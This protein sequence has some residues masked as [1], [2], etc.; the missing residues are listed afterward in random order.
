MDAKD[1]HI[2]AAMYGE[3]V[4]DQNPQVVTTTDRKESTAFFFVIFVNG[5]VYAIATASADAFS[6]SSSPWIFWSSDHGT[7]GFWGI[8]QS[9]YR[10]GMTEADGIPMHLIE[11]L[12]IF[13]AT[14][15]HSGPTGFR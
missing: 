7:N 14:Q 15:Q 2:L 12:A 10:M 1:P 3:E 6:E 9:C 5:L 8:Y 11:M 4:K 13:A